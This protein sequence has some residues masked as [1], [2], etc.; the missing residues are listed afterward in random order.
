MA[1]ILVASLPFAGHV[2]ALSG[3]AGEL[4]RRGHDVV[5]YT[6]A[7]HRRS[8]TD[9]GATWLPWAEATDFDDAD[10]PA[11]CL[12]LPKVDVMV[13]NGGWGGVLAAI[14]AGIP[15]VVAGGSLDK[16]QVA[17]RVAWSGAGIDLRTATPKPARIAH[18]VRE[19][20]SQARFRA[21]AGQ[22]GQALSSAGGVHKAGDLL[23][24]LLAR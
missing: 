2:A 19:V 22:L 23:E 16:P 15:L 3:V 1:R 13:T 11:A 4:V 21:R 17:R 9:A 12:L 20:M 18:A 10:L 24:G 5:A 6:G 8:F 14:Q 7:K